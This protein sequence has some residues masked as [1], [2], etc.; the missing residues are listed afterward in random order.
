MCVLKRL[1]LIGWITIILK[2][3]QADFFEKSACFEFSSQG[4]DMLSL[5]RQTFACHL[6]ALVELDGDKDLV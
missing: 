3:K 1:I 6:S 5:P 4:F 2:E